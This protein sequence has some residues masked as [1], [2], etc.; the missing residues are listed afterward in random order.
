METFTDTPTSG[1]QAYDAMTSLLELG[2]V[3]HIIVLDGE[4]LGRAHL[5]GGW[6]VRRALEQEMQVRVHVVTE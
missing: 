4:H 3:R 1:G 5:G 2:S 6:L